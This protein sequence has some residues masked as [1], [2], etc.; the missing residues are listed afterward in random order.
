M[1]LFPTAWVPWC[2]PTHSEHEAAECS[3]IQRVWIPNETQNWAKKR[4]VM[5]QLWVPLQWDFRRWPRM[6]WRERCP[7]QTIQSAQRRGICPGVWISLM[8]CMTPALD[9]GAQGGPEGHQKGQRDGT[10][11]ER[12]AWESWGQPAW[13]REGSREILQPVS[14]WRELIKKMETKFLIGPVVVEH[15]A[16]FLTERRKEY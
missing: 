12:A 14:T 16:M 4:F 3:L 8:F 2:L 1:L 7:G 9:P 5:Q 15:R 10:S 13:R 6:V 11:L